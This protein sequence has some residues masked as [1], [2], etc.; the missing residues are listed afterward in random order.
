VELRVRDTG[1]GIPVE[2]LD[3]V[4][5]RFYQ[6]S[7]TGDTGDVGTGIGLALTKELVE[8]HGG[9][10]QVESEEGW[11]ST[12]TVRLPLD[13]DAPESEEEAEAPEAAERTLEPRADA[14]DVLGRN[15]SSDERVVSPDDRMAER[16]DATVLVVEDNDDLRTYI[17]EHLERLCRVEE[18]ADGI[19]GLEM[20]RALRPDLILTDVMMPRMDGLSLCREVKADPELAHIPVVIL[21]AKVS[22]EAKIEGLKEGADDYLFKPFSADEIEARI[23]NLILIRRLLAERFGRTPVVEP[24]L[25]VET[26]DAQLLEQVREVILR[27]LSDQHLTVEYVA[28]EVAMSAR[29]LLRRLQPITHLT[30][31]GYIRL[32]RMERAAQLLQGGVRSVANVA[33]QVGYTDAVHFS[34]VFRETFGVLPSE[35]ER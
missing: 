1:R 2:E 35:Y 33:H 26:E 23:E 21:T 25:V 31:S 18:A 22:E 30:P 9:S 34:R 8:L 6:A 24:S 10:I 13:L 11:G 16:L 32:M 4:F 14:P 27:H 5:D 12:F 20:A 15:G 7:N 3:K 28:D 29:T 17:R 19:E